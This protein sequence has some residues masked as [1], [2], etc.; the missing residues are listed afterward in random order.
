MIFTVMN[1]NTI[2]V[3][4]FSGFYIRNCINCIHNCKDHSL[5]KVIIPCKSLKATYKQTRR[6][7][8]KSV[9]SILASKEEK[10]DRSDA[11]KDRDDTKKERII[12][13]ERK[14]S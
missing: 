5:L 14:R 6:Q 10:E 12:T 1:A 9:D 13:K 2:E 4:T 7:V 3:L 8:T 11:K